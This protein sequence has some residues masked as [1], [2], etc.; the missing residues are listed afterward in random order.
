MEQLGG[1]SVTHDFSFE[2][3]AGFWPEGNGQLIPRFQLDSIHFDF[4]LAIPVD[5][6]HLP[7]VSGAIQDQLAY[8]TVF[9]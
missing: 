2:S 9:P 4:E 3:I 7:S 8:L 1:K 6:S 5:A